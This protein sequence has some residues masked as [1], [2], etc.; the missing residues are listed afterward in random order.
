MTER[1]RIDELRDDTGNPDDLDPEERRLLAELRR[2]GPR[3]IDPVEE[4]VRVA[5]SADDETPL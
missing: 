4:S 1:P 3:V 2:P 5:R